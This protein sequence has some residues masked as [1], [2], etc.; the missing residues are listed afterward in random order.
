MRS[1]DE[2]S[3]PLESDISF[4]RRLLCGIPDARTLVASS[5]NDDDITTACEDE[6]DVCSAFEV[7]H[8]LLFALLVATIFAFEATAVTQLDAIVSCVCV[9]F[10][11]PPFVQSN[12]LKD[13]L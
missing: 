4:D 2:L 3:C 9:C 6:D 11:L 13:V 10:L 1:K 7:Q 12:F 5:R 8:F